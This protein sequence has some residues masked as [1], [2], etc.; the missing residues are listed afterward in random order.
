[1]PLEIREAAADCERRAGE[2]RQQA[3][4]VFLPSKQAFFL[5]LE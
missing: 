2:F 5:E 3:E 1:M 4:K